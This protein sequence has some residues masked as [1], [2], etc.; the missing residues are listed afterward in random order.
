MQKAC[1][2]CLGNV[3]NGQGQAIF[4]AEC[5]HSFH[6]SCIANSVRHGHYLCP[7]CRCKWKEIPF[8]MPTT[9]NNNTPENNFAWPHLT[10]DLVRYSDDEPL[11]VDPTC[12]PFSSTP[13]DCVSVKAVP[14]LPALATLNSASKFAVLVGVR[15]PPLLD[16]SRRLERAPIDLVAVLDVSASMAGSKLSLLKRAVHFVIDS[17]GLADRLSVVSFS[18]SARRIFPLRRMTHAGHEDAR[19]AVDSL[20]SNGGTNVVAG[21]KKGVRVLEERREQ[22]PV[23]SII[24]LS[25]GKDTYN[26]YRMGPAWALEYLKLLPVHTFGFG[27]DHDSNALHAIS[28]V[29]GGTFSFI[30]SVGLVQ[31][32]FARCIGGL[33]SVVA[34]ELRLAVTSLSPAGVEILSIPSARYAHEISEDRLRGAI[35]IGE[36]YAD[37]EK[38]F[39]V[40]V[41]VPVCHKTGKTP[42]LKITCSYRDITKSVVKV[43]G[44]RVE[45]R[46][47][48]IPSPEDGIVS[49][50]VDCQKVRLSVIE[51]IE[52]AKDL[53]ESGNLAGAKVLLT[54]ANSDL[55]SLAS[56]RSGN[57]L[58]SLLEAELG[59]IRRRMANL[60]TYEHEGR[61]YMLSGLSSHSSQRS[62]TRSSNSGPVGYDTPSMVTMVSHSQTLSAEYYYRE[63]A[64]RLTRSTRV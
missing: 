51:A 2:I 23:A 54:S 6:F 62:T 8:Q 38:E 24:L 61:A 27:A 22:N 31:D 11:L 1:A 48:D 15:A 20:S 59:E 43:E 9:P 17:L 21:L 13:S 44:E 16:D 39:L 34:Y 10:S 40:Y 28:E 53:A 57:G 35:T 36:L 33:L 5:S 63:Q 4:T 18:S 47:P 30:E 42:L 12:N 45:I 25:D 52:E 19:L 55:L 7:I 37:E 3:R 56:A 26:S 60:H 41:S 46:R 14:E 49:L 58:C 64:S 32:A 50:E 29:S